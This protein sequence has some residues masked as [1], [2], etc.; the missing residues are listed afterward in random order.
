LANPAVKPERMTE[1]EAGLD[2]SLFNDK[3][4]LTFTGYNQEI[5][6]LVVNAV[7]ASTTGGTS[8]VNNTGQMSNK[9]VEIGMNL[10]VIKTKDF[11]WDASIIFN[12][13]KSRVEKL[14]TALVS[15]ANSAG[16]PIYLIEG[17]APSVFYGV[18]YARDA[19]GNL[20]LNS[21]G[22]PQREKGTQNGA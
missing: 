14:G 2:L 20:L 15:I 17:Q 13:N 10:S 11:S 1:F 21:Q 5:N 16:A 18:P 4:G 3:V 7:S 8:I 12:K 6:E 9:G 19:D 22:F